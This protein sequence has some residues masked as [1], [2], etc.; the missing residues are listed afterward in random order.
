M[1]DRDKIIC[2]AVIIYSIIHLLF[3]TSTHLRH[4]SVLCLTMSAV[5][6]FWWSIVGVRPK[7][8]GSPETIVTFTNDYWLWS[9]ELLHQSLFCQITAMVRINRITHKSVV[10]KWSVLPQR[11]EEKSAKSLCNYANQC[12]KTTV[13]KRGF[14]SLYAP[15]TEQQISYSK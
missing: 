11:S 9:A 14:R 6:A 15:A 8:W 7:C 5:T 2:Q 3:T 10:F 12:E 13:M 4:S 1:S